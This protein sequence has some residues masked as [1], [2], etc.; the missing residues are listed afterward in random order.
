MKDAKVAS[1]DEKRIAEKGLHTMLSVE[2]FSV[3]TFS[4]RETPVGMVVDGHR[5]RLTA[6][7]AATLAARILHVLAHVDHDEDG[8]RGP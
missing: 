7:Q 6:G 3:G 8:T 4:S 2:E 5:Y 1:L